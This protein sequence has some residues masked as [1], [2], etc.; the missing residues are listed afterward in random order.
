MTSETAQIIIAFGALISAIAS[1]VA[2]VLSALN[3]NTIKDVETLGKKTHDLTNS[4][5]QELLDV[6]RT[7]AEARGRLE[8]KQ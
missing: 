5:M 1:S 7:S 2:V 3:R 8:S 4:K 6:T